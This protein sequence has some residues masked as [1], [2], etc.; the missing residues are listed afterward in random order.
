MSYFLLGVLG[1]LRIS[2]SV[3]IIL[4]VNAKRKGESGEVEENGP[5]G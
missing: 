5:M 3:S 2:D 1:G 4:E